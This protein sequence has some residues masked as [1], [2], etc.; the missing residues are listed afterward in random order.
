VGSLLC[1]LW[2]GAPKRPILPKGVDM[3]EYGLKE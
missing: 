1:R 3:V 2:W